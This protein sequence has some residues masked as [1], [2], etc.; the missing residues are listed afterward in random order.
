MLPLFQQKQ[1]HQFGIYIVILPK[2]RTMLP[3]KLCTYIALSLE[4]LY[5]LKELI[6]TDYNLKNHVLLLYRLKMGNAITSINERLHPRL[7]FMSHFP[8]YK[9]IVCCAYNIILPTSKS[10]GCCI[11]LYFFSIIVSLPRF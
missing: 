8:D 2:K 4:F 5:S 10:H 3:I 7:M 9:C 11:S 1:S 6:W